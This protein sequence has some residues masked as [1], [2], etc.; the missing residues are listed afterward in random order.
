[1][2]AALKLNESK[3]HFPEIAQEH[4][5]VLIELLRDVNLE[6]RMET[7]IKAQHLFDQ[8]DSLLVD[9]QLDSI[10]SDLEE[11]KLQLRQMIFMV[12]KAQHY[13]RE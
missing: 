5:E 2:T 1:M 9:A 3:R 4:V 7:L 13:I 8:P 10:R 6:K 12:D 11:Y